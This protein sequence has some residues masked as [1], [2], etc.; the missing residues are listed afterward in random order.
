MKPTRTLIGLLTAATLLVAPAL[1]QAGETLDRVTSTGT[2]T[3]SSD[4][5]YPPQSFL[6]DDNEMDGFDVDVGREIAK[7]MG[8]E[9]EIVTPAWEVITAGNWNGRWDISVGSMTPTKTRAEVL[10]FPAVYYYVPASFAVHADSAIDSKE[11]LNGKT[12]G[13]CGGCTYENYLNEN[14][15]IDALGAPDFSYDVKAG[16]IRTYETDTNAFDD[17]RLGDGTR[18]DAVLSAQPTIQEAIKNGY[19]MEIVGTPAFYEPLAVATDKGDE[20]FDAK[21]KEII[22]AMHED[23]TLSELSEKWYGVDY[24]TTE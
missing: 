2:L 8:V 9:I 7:R 19:P 21:I 6:N 24:T 18:L 14:L 20:E 15:V 4:P 10:D 13:V 5:A 12:I 1:A 22:N 3:L 16:E 23:G 11:A 17:L